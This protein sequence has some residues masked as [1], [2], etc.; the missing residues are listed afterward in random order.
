MA[1]NTEIQKFVRPRHGFIPKTGW[2]G[3]VKEVDGVPTLRGANRA[4]HAIEP[5]QPKNVRPSRGGARP[6]RTRCCRTEI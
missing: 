5:C 2:I 6:H 4:R 3:H 1:T